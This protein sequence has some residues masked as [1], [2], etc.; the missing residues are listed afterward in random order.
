MFYGVLSLATELLRKELN[1]HKFSSVEIRLISKLL[2][3]FCRVFTYNFGI[4]FAALKYFVARQR[5]FI[6]FLVFKLVFTCVN[7]PLKDPLCHWNL[8]NLTL[9]TFLSNTR[10]FGRLHSTF[11]RL[12]NAAASPAS[13]LRSAGLVGNDT[14]T[15]EKAKN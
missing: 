10:D 3:C 12:Y 11:A 5:Y 7:R 6:S 1:S 13:R 9:Q 2:A 15:I 8:R 14:C 4:S